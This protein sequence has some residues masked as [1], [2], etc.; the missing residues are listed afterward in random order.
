VLDLRQ[1]EVAVQQDVQAALARLHRSAV[2][3]ET[4][5]KQ[6]LPNLTKSLEAMQKLFQANVGG[7]DV[8]RIIDVGR[9]LINARDS[10]LDAQWE[11]SQAWADLVA[12]VGDPT[13]FLGPDAFP[14][15]CGCLPTSTNAH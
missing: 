12:A 3:V 6:V 9:S 1:T 5:E 7:V 10:Y 4:F 14:A 13:V 2:L 11:W 8:L 15:P